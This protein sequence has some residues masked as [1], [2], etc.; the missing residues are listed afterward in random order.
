[1]SNQNI[2]QKSFVTRYLLWPSLLGLYVL[3]GVFCASFDSEKYTLVMSGYIAMTVTTIIAAGL[4]QSLNR[5]FKKSMFTD[6]RFWLA[7]CALYTILFTLL[8]N[9]PFWD[10]RGEDPIQSYG[11]LWDARNNFLTC[12]YGATCLGSLVIAWFIFGRS[13][14][15]AASKIPESSK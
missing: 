2:E 14:R 15:A 4:K 3:G 6:H 7:F 10:V 1:L 11:S 5:V 12:L 13:K 9:I 8:L